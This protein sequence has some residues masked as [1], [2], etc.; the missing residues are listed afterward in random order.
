MAIDRGADERPRLARILVIDDS[1]FVV[2]AVREAL[3]PHGHKVETLASFLEL[4]DRLRDRPPDLIVLDVEM[5]MMPGP[6]V[7]EYIRKYQR[8]AI[9]IL[10]YSSRPNLELARIALDLRAHGFVNK[11]AG[12]S[13]LV[14]KIGTILD[15]RAAAG[16][17]P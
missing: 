6:K 5:P 3:A 9:P 8:A 13:R 4:V 12:T 14:E 16:A 11:Q 17:G 7:G 1:E 2:K 10:V 15:A